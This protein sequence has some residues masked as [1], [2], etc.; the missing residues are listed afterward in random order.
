MGAAENGGAQAQ[1]QRIVADL[2]PETPTSA[3][4]VIVECQKR[5]GRQLS[6]LTGVRGVHGA[7]L[8][9][10]LRCGRMCG[11]VC[12]LAPELQTIS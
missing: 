11:P 12:S 2:P 5:D 4:K 10:C 1:W 3:V 8:K 6:V 7:T 9:R